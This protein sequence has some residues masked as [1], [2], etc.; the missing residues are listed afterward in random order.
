MKKQF[1]KKYPYAD[2]SKFDFES[3]FDKNGNFQ[4]SNIYFK[5]NDVL[6]TDI[7]SDTF[8]NDPNMTKYLTINKP[9][10]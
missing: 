6:S 8:K 7:T 2:M 5:N 3:D 4:G 1:K 10:E 9:V